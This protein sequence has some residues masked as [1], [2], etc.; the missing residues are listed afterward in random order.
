MHLCVVAV[1]VRIWVRV[2][3]SLYWQPCF[4]LL[5]LLF[6]FAYFLFF[7]VVFLFNIFIMRPQSVPVSTWKFVWLAFFE[8]ILLLLLFLIFFFFFLVLLTLKIE[9]TVKLYN[10]FMS[11]KFVK[12]L[13]FHCFSLFL[14]SFLPWA[15]D[16]W[17]LA[18]SSLIGLPNLVIALPTY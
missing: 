15:Y 5:L 12:L 2:C 14:S 6:Y 13:P 4:F 9:E 17:P 7:V 16:W 1:A 8:I 18:S 11:S 3:L 10:V